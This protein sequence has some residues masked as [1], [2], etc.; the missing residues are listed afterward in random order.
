M[1]P[2]NSKIA[3]LG[4]AATT[5]TPAPDRFTTRGKVAESG[6]AIYRICGTW[7]V[8][9]P[10]GLDCASFRRVRVLSVRSGSRTGRSCT[11]RRSRRSIGVIVALP[12]L[13]MQALVL[14]G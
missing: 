12:A 10:C 14:S 5:L 13:A 7:F 2:P 8:P 1:T 4:G 6:P 9:D 3:A 11:A